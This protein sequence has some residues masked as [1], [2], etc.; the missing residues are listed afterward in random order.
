MIKLRTHSCLLPVLSLL[1]VVALVSPAMAGIPLEV[2]LFKS[3]LLKLNKKMVLVTLANT[4]KSDQE[5]DADIVAKSD[6]IDLERRRSQDAGPSNTN[7][8]VTLD[9]LSP[10]DLKLDG[11]MIGTTSMIVWT[12]DDKD[13]RPVSTF[14]DVKVTG[15]R[16][17]IEAQLKE[18]APNDAIS[19]QFANDTAILTGSVANEQTRLKAENTARA[20][21]PKVLNH[22]AIDNPQQVLLQVKVAQMDKTALKNLGISFLIKGSKGEG[23]S[24]MVGAP[25]GSSSSSSSS[26]SSGGISGIASSLGS[27]TPLDAYQIGAAYFPGGVGAVLQALSTKGYAKILAEPNMLVKSGQEGNFLAGSKIPYSVLLSSGGT[28]TTTIVFQDVGVKLKFKPEVLENGLIN[29]KLDPAEVSSIS[30]TLA[31]NG[32]PI[33]DI[34]TLQTSVE[35]KDGESLVLAGLLQEE[36]IKTMSKIPLLGDIPILGALF[37]S[38]QDS[39]TEKELV[40]FITPKIVK[41]LAPG[42]RQE[43]P[44]DR[45]LTPEQERELKW[46]PLGE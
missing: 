34:R 21:A 9:V 11:I 29:L 1:L 39:T 2:G 13:E 38:T 14:Y 23:F 10:Y 33:I 41:P 26:S 7:K 30:G 27:Y 32:Y 5:K 44:T 45:K 8:F 25:S 22:I 18:I 6:K 46:M 16:S 3:T 35:L 20:F 15:D 28:T 4:R 40:F 43:L 37:R 17:A 12:K 42:V 24:N 19:V 31:V 36:A